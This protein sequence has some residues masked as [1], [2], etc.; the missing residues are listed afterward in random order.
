[1]AASATWNSCQPWSPP[2]WCS[3]S[4]SWVRGFPYTA[5]RAP[6][7]LPGQRQIFLICGSRFTHTHY[8]EIWVSTKENTYLPAWFSMIPRVLCSLDYVSLLEVFVLEFSIGPF[9]PGE[10]SSVLLF[11]F[12]VLVFVELVDNFYPFH[13]WNDYT[14][15]KDNEIY[16]Y[17]F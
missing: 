17:K 3:E 2:H 15:L 8:Q 1:M 10:S 14:R 9:L 16:R 6:L 7:P 13:P 4:L 12:T 11:W 5:L